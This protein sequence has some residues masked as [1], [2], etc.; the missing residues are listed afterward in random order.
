MEILIRLTWHVK[1][2]N[3]VYFFDVDSSG[4]EVCCDQNP[5]FYVLK[6]IIDLIPS[7]LRKVTIASFCRESFLFDNLAQFLCVL[8]LTC[9]NDNLV[10]LKVV[11]KLSEFHDFF[12]FFK[13]DVVLFQT[14]QSEF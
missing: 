3:D 4:E 9:K 10:K 11:E 6:L 13:L 12:P 2:D 7:L 1:V 8:L 5:E 14:M